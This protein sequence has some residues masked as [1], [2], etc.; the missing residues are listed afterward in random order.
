MKKKSL[1][2]KKTIHRSLLNHLKYSQVRKVFNGY[3]NYL[4]KFINKKSKIGVAVSGGPDSLAL[5]YLTKCYSLKN[6]LSSNFFLI[7]H[8]LR[9]ESSKEAKSVKL[10]LEKFDIDCEIIKWKGKKPNSNI[11]S[12]ARNKRYNLLKKACKKNNIRYLLIGH[13]TD[14]L[15]E[16][17]FIRLVRGSGLR[18]LSSFGEPI[19]E[20]DSF[21]ILRPLIKFKKKDLIYI[22]KLIFNFFIEDPSNENFF[23]LR[24]RIRKLIADL[25]KEGFNQKKLDLTIKNLKSANDGINFYV[26][27]NINNNAKFIENKKV[28]ILN[29][30]FF[31]QSEEVIF[32]SITLVLK[33]ISGRY[34]SPRGKSILDSIVKINSLK[35]K[36]FTLGGCFIEKINETVFITSEN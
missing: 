3:R 10:L 19:K 31:N 6:K 22:S 26:K 20:E 16:N 14:D 15:Y 25:N 18:G 23:F 34:Y 12:I 9:K 35:C 13:H 11:Q 30:Y 33:K 7:D 36:R 21:F 2:A 1:A 8:A 5:A 32:R 28:Y 17:F 29:K 24:S 27:K 4:D